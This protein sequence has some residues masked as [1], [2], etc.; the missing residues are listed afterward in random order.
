[1]YDITPKC[2]LK[3]NSNKKEMNCYL[4][5]TEEFLYETQRR[6]HNPVKY[7]RWTVLRKKL[8]VFNR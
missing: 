4:T 1:M 8:T 7:L 5:K 2:S 6:I 3:R